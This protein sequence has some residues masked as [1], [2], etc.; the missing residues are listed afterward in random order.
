MCKVTLIFILCLILSVYGQESG[1]FW[2]KN[3]KLMNQVSNSRSLK[4]Q[5]AKIRTLPPRYRHE[6]D[7]ISS[8]TTV[9]GLFIHEEQDEE[10]KDHSQYKY[11]NEPD[12]VCVSRQ[13]CNENNTI[14]TDGNGLI[15]E[16]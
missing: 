7:D 13:L 16:R 10:N 14:I 6:N 9:K 3:K 2:W 1:S 8:T 5:S 15:D 11:D 4:E 12:C